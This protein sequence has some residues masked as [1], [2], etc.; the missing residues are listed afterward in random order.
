MKKGKAGFVGAASPPPQTPHPAP[1]PCEA[2][3]C[4]SLL[5]NRV[6]YKYFEDIIMWGKDLATGL[7]TDNTSTLKYIPFS[8]PL[9]I[10]NHHLK[11]SSLEKSHYD[12]EFR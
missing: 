6:D 7:A 10:R 5:L 3:C 2:N 12:R 4:A 1:F 8:R 9:A 11:D